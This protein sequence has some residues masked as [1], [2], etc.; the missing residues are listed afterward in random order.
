MRKKILSLM[1]VGLLVFSSNFSTLT[2]A[3]TRPEES[4]PTTPQREAAMAELRDELRA[5][6]YGSGDSFTVTAQLG[7]PAKLIFSQTQPAKKNGLSTG[8]KVGIGVGLAAIV[9]IIIAVTANGNDRQEVGQSPCRD[10][11]PPGPCF[12]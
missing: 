4:A 2:F 8:A 1:L 10:P 6:R 11:R 5:E 9:G 3:Q 12:Q 7:V